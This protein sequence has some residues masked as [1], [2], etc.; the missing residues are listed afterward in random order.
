MKMLRRRD[1]AMH[2]EENLATVHH[3]TESHAANIAAALLAMSKP[4]VPPEGNNLIAPLVA[5]NPIVNPL[6]TANLVSI[7]IAEGAKKNRGASAAVGGDVVVAAV[8]ELP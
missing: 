2:V 8:N 5:N 1:R 7:A 4:D 3:A 6:S